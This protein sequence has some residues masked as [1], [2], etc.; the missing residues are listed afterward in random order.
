MRR[1]E[2]RLDWRGKFP[3]RSGELVHVT[4][5][6]QTAFRIEGWLIEE[7]EK[8]SVVKVRLNRT[9]LGDYHPTPNR[10]W[11]TLKPGDS[12]VVDLHNGEPEPLS[13]RSVLAGME[14]T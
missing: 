13:F 5:T 12:I 2:H 11:P 4:F 3:I 7:G 9:T 14:V 6:S 8:V 1:A 10:P